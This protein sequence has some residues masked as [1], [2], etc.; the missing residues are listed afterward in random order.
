MSR[1]KDLL[2]RLFEAAA[3]VRT[4]LGVLLMVDPIRWTGSSGVG[5]AWYLKPSPPERTKTFFEAA[6][7]APSG[8]P[9]SVGMG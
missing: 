9:H 2:D 3:R 6:T 4:P 8:I 5:E 7:L 1:S